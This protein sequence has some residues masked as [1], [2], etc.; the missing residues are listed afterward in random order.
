MKNKSRWFILGSLVF[1]QMTLC[2]AHALT[3][4]SAGL[5]QYQS[6][7]S[8]TYTLK[9][10]FGTNIAILT[11]TNSVLNATVMAQIVTA[12]DKAYDLYRQATGRQPTSYDPTTLYGRD[13]ISVVSAT[14]GAG[15]GYLGF[16]GIEILE[17]YFNTLYNGVAANNQYDQV[18]FYELGRNFWFYSDQL[19]YH[20]PDS[21]PVVTGYA[22]Y[23]RFVAMDAAGVA[24]GPF[25]GYSFTT[26]RTTVTNLMDSYITNSS[27]NWS[28]TFRTGTAPPNPLGL[29]GTDLIASLLMR[30]GRDFGDV[31]FATNFWRQAALRPAAA[32]TQATVDNFILTACATVNQN[33]SGIFTTTWK[34]PMSG[35]AAQEAQTRW[36]A[37]VVLHPPVAIGKGVGGTILLK[38][39]TQVNTA[40]QLQGSTNLQSWT[41]IG[42]P[43]TGD[44][45]IRTVTNSTSS[46]TT[47][48]FRLKLQ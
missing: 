2:P 46:F 42:T 28:N 13:A 14:C 7:Q 29:G 39:Q 1:A 40:Y 5:V 27:L 20:S 22:V 4:N 34:F 38:W 19:Q 15:C 21:D 11:P 18:L 41:D 16:N 47:R 43:V 9:P 10:W 31:S 32:T 26:F 23:M 17:S 8:Q 6:F 35:S 37:P 36:G 24:G 12:L 30:I 45:A 25:N 44:G 48:F 3:T 33:L